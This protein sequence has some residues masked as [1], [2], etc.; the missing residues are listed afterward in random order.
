M[1]N[2]D[3][4]LKTKEY[5]YDFCGFDTDISELNPNLFEFQKQIVKWALKKGKCALF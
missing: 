4:F 5:T 3:E 2:Y 1:Q